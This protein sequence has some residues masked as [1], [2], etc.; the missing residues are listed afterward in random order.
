VLR[1]L[2]HHRLGRL[3][4]FNAVH[5]GHCEEASEIRHLVGCFALLWRS[6][7][8]SLLCSSLP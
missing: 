6:F 7:V 3:L 5:E 8:F 2:L 4:C 1:H